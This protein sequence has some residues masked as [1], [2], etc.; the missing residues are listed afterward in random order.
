MRSLR[1]VLWTFWGTFWAI[2]AARF[3]VHELLSVS[4]GHAWRHISMATALFAAAG[5]LITCVL[6]S[7]DGM[8][9]HT[10]R[11]RRG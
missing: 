11:L 6:S 1:Y 5:I 7:I 2:L 4:T 3:A 8:L 10:R 9:R